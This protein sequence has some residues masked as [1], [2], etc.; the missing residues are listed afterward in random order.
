MF[1]FIYLQNHSRWTTI[2]LSLDPTNES[3]TFNFDIPTKINEL[4]YY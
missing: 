1:G 3:L 2:V 4:R